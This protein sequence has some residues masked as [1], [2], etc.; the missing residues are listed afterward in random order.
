M[1]RNGWPAVSIATDVTTPPRRS[2][3][4][5]FTFEHFRSLLNGSLNCLMTNCLKTS[6]AHLSGVFAVADVVRSSIMVRRST[7]MRLR[8][9]SVLCCQLPSSI[10]TRHRLRSTWTPANYIEAASHTIPGRDKRK[11]RS[12]RTMDAG[13]IEQRKALA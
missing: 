7:T 9:P 6:C 10:N 3:L 2:A 8:P 1:L 13:D 11:N 4:Q 12:E 5:K